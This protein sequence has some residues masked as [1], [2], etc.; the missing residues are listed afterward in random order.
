MVWPSRCSEAQQGFVW[1]GSHDTHSHQTPAHISCQFSW[2]VI[3]PLS[4]TFPPNMLVD[5]QLGISQS[6][7]WAL[8][9]M[10]F[11]DVALLAMLS[12]GVQSILLQE[13]MLP[14]NCSVCGCPLTAD[15]RLTVAVQVNRAKCSV[16]RLV[17]QG[18]LE[19]V[20]ITACEAPAAALRGGTPSLSHVPSA[21]WSLTSGMQSRLN[22]KPAA[23]YAVMSSMP[24]QPDAEPGASLPLNTSMLPKPDADPAAS[25][26]RMSSRLP[27]PSAEPG[28]SIHG[29]SSRQSHP[30][31]EPASQHSSP[32]LAASP[33]CVS[34]SPDAQLHRSFPQ[35]AINSLE[36][37][38]R[39]KQDA[40]LCAPRSPQTSSLAPSSNSDYNSTPD[41]PSIAETDT[42]AA[43]S[44]E[45][46]EAQ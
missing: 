17:L 7:M 35:G 41:A 14:V 19:P 1:H 37:P 45:A 3:L 13:L 25:S 9:F 10:H 16:Q 4:C 40:Q 21:G 38:A 26:A 15:V 36:M 43:A 33:S 32:G 18:L 27:Q 39:G 28:A 22:Y 8:C 42:P 5:P 31:A 46:S 11:N 20:P 44:G 29:A 23:S 2:F 30:W 24:S 34:G 12:S 6:L